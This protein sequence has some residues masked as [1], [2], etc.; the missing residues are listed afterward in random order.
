MSFSA[1]RGPVGRKARRPCH[2]SLHF[3]ISAFSGPAS[4]Q[5]ELHRRVQ[6]QHR[7]GRCGEDGDAPAVTDA[8]GCPN[9]PPLPAAASGGW[10]CRWCW[11]FQRQA[12]DGGRLSWR[13][14]DFRNTAP[15]PPCRKPPR[16]IRDRPFVARSH[17]SRDRARARLR[18][19]RANKSCRVTHRAPGHAASP[20]F[21]RKERAARRR[22]RHGAAGHLMQSAK[23]KSA[24]GRC[25]RSP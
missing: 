15:S 10:L 23:C 25:C 24:S 1:G 7:Q 17:R 3:E 5:F 18:E 6:R 14:C 2:R 9:Q 4:D 21:R 12:E 19:G 16:N 13:A 20:R 22:S 11:S 8:V